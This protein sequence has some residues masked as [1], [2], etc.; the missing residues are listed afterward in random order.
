MKERWKY[1]K[2]GE[3]CTI[4]GG[5]TPK[6]EELSS[7][8]VY[9]YYKV[10]DMNTLGNSIYLDITESYKES[11][12]KFFKKGTI[13]FPK[14]GAAVATNKKRIL[15][16]DSIVDL[17]TAAACFESSINEKFAYYWFI[18]TD[19][20]NFVRGGALPTLDIKSL[21]LKPFP[22]VDKSTQLS[23]VSELDKINELIRLKKEQLKDYDNLAQSIFYEMFGDP[24]EN[25][26]GWEVKAL[27]DFATL[28]NGRAYSKNELLDKGKYRVL[29]VGNLFSTK[30]FYY[31]DLELDEDKYI[32]SGDLIYS[33][34]CTFG[35]HIWHEE[36]VIYHYHIWKVLLKDYIDKQYARFLLNIT[37]KYLMNQ[38]HGIGM[39]HF[40]KSSMEKNEFPVPPLHLQ[41]QFA[42][43]I[44]LI[45][46]QKAEVQ[47]AINDLETLLASRM[48]YWFE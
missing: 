19:F 2:L 27:E 22:F 43:R 26:K 1:K 21:L 34:S 35:A 31:S 30:D 20:K 23:I 37:T 14:N 25:E 41:Q 40:T 28:V 13:V 15:K 9:P 33:W 29:R 39:M 24:V 38:T 47:K 42:S 11:T 4:K 7:S 45:E 18:D 36:K 17:N 12:E 48:Q 3:V 6:P 16:Y 8:G 10:A 44:S 32:E 5:F 46:Q